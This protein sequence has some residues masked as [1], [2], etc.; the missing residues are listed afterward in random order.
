LALNLSTVFMWVAE[1]SLALR[2]LFRLLNVEAANS[3]VNWVYEVSGAFLAPLRGVF[4]V[5]TVESGNV[6]D[7]P[8]LFAMVVYALFALLVVLVVA[9][10]T[11]RR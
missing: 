1:A 2:V 11:V 10:L 5:Q 9:R 6:L 8:A 7:V 3:F 4:P